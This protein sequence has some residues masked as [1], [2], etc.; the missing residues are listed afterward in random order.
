MNRNARAYRLIA[1]I[2]VG[3]RE[4][5]V[6][7]LNE[8]VGAK[9][10]ETHLPPD[11]KEKCLSG[12]QSE[13]RT[14]WM[15]LYDHHPVYYLDFPDLRKILE[16]RRTWGY[17]APYFKS[18]QHIANALS[19]LE[20]IRNRVAHNRHVSDGQLAVLDGS[21]AKLNAMLG[22]QTLTKHIDE[23]SERTSIGNLVVDVCSAMN[24][25]IAE[26][27]KLGRLT[28]LETVESCSASWWWNEEYLPSDY[29][30]MMLVAEQ[31]IAYSSLPRG[32]GRGHHI[33]RWVQ[34]I[35]L[36]E[37]QMTV[38]EAVRAAQRMNG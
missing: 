29:H 31:I 33:E 21:L 1:I 26:I 28:E 17:F 10:W 7:V 22:D 32:R 8:E 16:S 11:L 35:D 5:V 34:E 14:P 37:W 36:E 13:R 23:K 6:E 38:A 12:I 20:P 27:R 25:C 19:D 3:L 9:W 2:E 30:G 18:K 15:D 4:L 24:I